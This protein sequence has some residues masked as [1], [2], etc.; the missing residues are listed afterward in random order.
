MLVRNGPPHL[1]FFA[2]I[3]SKA[4]ELYA[5][6]HGD[7]GIHLNAQVNQKDGDPFWKVQLAFVRARSAERIARKY[8]QCARLAGYAVN[9][10]FR[11]ALPQALLRIVYALMPF[12]IRLRN[13][14]W[15]EAANAYRDRAFQ[16]VKLAAWLAGDAGDEDCLGMAI[17]TASILAEEP[18]E[19][20]AVWA[21]QALPTIANEK[22][23]ADLLNR[24]NNLGQ[25]RKAPDK[26][27]ISFAEEQQI[28]EQMA[29]SLGIDLSATEDRIA[30]IVRIGLQDLD[31]G[32]VLKNCEHLFVSL[33]S[34]GAVG[35]WM[36]L[37]TA[38]SKLLHCTLHGN[39]VG[40]MSLDDVYGLF[41]QNYCEKCKD[42]AP[43]P[44]EWEYTRTWQLEQNVKHA[45]FA[46]RGQF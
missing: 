2:L 32:R 45:K 37:P 12:L 9:Y 42:C 39:S 11:W 20:I 19:E 26:E 17:A 23:R 7:F 14:D 38:G 30:W 1:K 25:S 16:I 3:A 21:R 34:H 46:E 5:L 28:Y 33:G 4:A 35:D 6:V 43:H 40:G 41:K 13:D 27:E 31:P 44:P 10:P 15:K 22:L 18:T 29:A 24:L 36:R 8:N